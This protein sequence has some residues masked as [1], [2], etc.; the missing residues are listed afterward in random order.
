MGFSGDNSQRVGKACPARHTRT[1]SIRD[2]IQ[3]KQCLQ[4]ALGVAALVP[5][6]ESVSAF[7]L[8]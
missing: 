1:V 3:S 6:G 5:Y 7:T 8:Q 4:I 2:Q